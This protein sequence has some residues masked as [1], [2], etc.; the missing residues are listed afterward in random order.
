MIQATRI[1]T[2][3][4]RQR[5]QRLATKHKC[6][7]KHSLHGEDQ[8]ISKLHIMNSKR[9]LLRFWYAEQATKPK[10]NQ[11]LTLPQEIILLIASHLLHPDLL[12]LKACHPHLDS[13]ITANWR[14]QR[15]WLISHLTLHSSC[16]MEKCKLG[17]GRD[18]CRGRCA[19]VVANMTSH[20]ECKRRRGGRGCVVSGLK[21]PCRLKRSNW[22]KVLG[23]VQMIMAPFV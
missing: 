11:I 12:N 6:L 14:T 9:R 19:L 4:E 7:D 16:P 18:Y 23:P 22:D 8:Q 15:E 3:Q 10:E 5:D 17:L 1:H 20:V 21:T 13:I 2:K